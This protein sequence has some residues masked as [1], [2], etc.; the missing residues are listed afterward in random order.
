MDRDPRAQRVP[1][2]PLNPGLPLP[3]QYREP[4]VGQTAAR[5]SLSR[6][7]I[8]VTPFPSR[9]S[10]STTAANILTGDPR[11]VFWLVTNRGATDVNLDI[12]TTAVAGQGVLLA[13]GGGWASCDAL[14]DGEAPTWPVSVVAASGTPQ[15]WLYEVRAT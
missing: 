6:W 13:A 8:P 11:R 10:A 9:P 5:F 15:L 1:S 14:E 7:G 3:S 4:S 2:A 12:G